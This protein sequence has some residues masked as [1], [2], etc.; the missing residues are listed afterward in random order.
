MANKRSLKRSI[1][2]ICGELFS[3]GVAISVYYN[4]DKQNADTLL[5][6]IMRM[7]SDYIM[8]IS[9]PEPGMSGKKYFKK[10]IS[11]FNNSVNEVV[12]HMKNLHA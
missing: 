12:D 1:N 10:L 7:H 9:H 11:D 5:R 4:C 3:E 8:R 2:A 6:T